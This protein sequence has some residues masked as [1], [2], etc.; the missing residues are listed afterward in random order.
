MCH[1][2]EYAQERGENC[3]GPGNHHAKQPTKIAALRA[4]EHIQPPV[5]PIHASVEPI[6][7]TVCVR[8]ACLEP[9]LNSFQ[10]RGSHASKLLQHCDPGFHTTGISA[11]AKRFNGNIRHVHRSMSAAGSLT[12]HDKELP[13]P[14]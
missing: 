3:P 8:Q 1:Y 12:A 9:P 4:P 13:A 10:R 5:D 6:H 14:P 7:A 11:A 2:A